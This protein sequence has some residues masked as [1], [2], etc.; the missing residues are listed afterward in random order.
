MTLKLNVCIE[1]FGST[2][3]I[4]WIDNEK[5]KGM[6]VQADS[7]ENARRELLISLK[8]KIA[9]DFGIHIGAINT[10]EHQDH[11]CLEFAG[12]KKIGISK[13]EL[14]DISLILM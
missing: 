5:F 1:K 10:T 14:D 4:A 7:P 8:T 13:T 12:D 3:Y 6:V 11:D 2:G 9:Y